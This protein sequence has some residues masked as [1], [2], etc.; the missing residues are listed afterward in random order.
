MATPGARASLNSMN[1][2][3]LQPHKL[4]GFKVVPK[5]LLG[6]C[7]SSSQS[8]Y[9]VLLGRRGAPAS[10]RERVLFVHYLDRFLNVCQRQIEELWSKH[11][12][13]ITH[14]AV[15]LGHNA[16]PAHGDLARSYERALSVQ[17]LRQKLQPRFRRL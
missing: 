1:T 16:V 2:M 15:K 17:H 14:V 3:P 11:R 10:P 13:M 4:P 12:V 5:R 6:Q 7:F 9:Y 8:A